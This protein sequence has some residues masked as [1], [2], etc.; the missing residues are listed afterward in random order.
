MTSTA[1]VPH[2]AYD[3]PGPLVRRFDGLPNQ[4]VEVTFD[5]TILIDPPESL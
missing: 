4:D 5:I 1:L 2:D 3:N